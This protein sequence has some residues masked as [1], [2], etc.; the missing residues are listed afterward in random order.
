MEEEEDWVNLNIGRMIAN[1]KK[2][3][4]YG[5][6]GDPVS[7]YSSSSGDKNISYYGRRVPVISSTATKHVIGG[8]GIKTGSN[9]NGDYHNENNE[10]Q[11]VDNLFF[12]DHNQFEHEYVEFLMRTREIAEQAEV[13]AEIPQHC[14]QR[15]PL[16]SQYFKEEDDGASESIVT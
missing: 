3:N 15:N 16:V 5:G 6:C 13:L 12:G 10:N 9:D 1:F 14:V 2:D 4:I 11:E 7:A 8:S